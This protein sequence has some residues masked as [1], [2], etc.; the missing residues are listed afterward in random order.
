MAENVCIRCGDAHV[1]AG[2]FCP[3]C[4][5]A[6]RDE[7]RLGAYRHYKGGTYTLLCI[8][9][10]SSNHSNRPNQRIAIY[11][12][13]QRRTVRVRELDEFLEPVVWPD[14]VT[15]PR[16]DLMPDETPEAP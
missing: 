9:R 12:S 14:G 3:A 13:H 10:D 1:A 7:T 8:A 16:F 4:I 5:D 6:L 15:R 2:C 11:V